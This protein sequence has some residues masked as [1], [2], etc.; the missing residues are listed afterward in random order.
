MSGAEMEIFRD[1]LIRGEAQQLDALMDDLEKLLP[2]G[3][4]RDRAME[5]QLRSLS[6]L[7]KP[8]YSFVHESEDRLPAV[9]IF[10]V[11]EEPGLLIASNIVPHNKRRLS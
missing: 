8:C 5:G 3:W 2:P 10:L 1:M 4:V 11:E 9:T 6:R 7:A